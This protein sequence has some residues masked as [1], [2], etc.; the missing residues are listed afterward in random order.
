LGDLS[1]ADFNLIQHNHRN[2]VAIALKEVGILLDAAPGDFQ[3]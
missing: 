3:V 2:P 1:T